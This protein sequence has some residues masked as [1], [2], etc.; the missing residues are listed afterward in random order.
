[1]VD[2]DESKKNNLSGS[3]YGP[4]LYLSLTGDHKIN[5]KVIKL[6]NE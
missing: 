6:S 4:L 2:F 1:M 5:R 3:T